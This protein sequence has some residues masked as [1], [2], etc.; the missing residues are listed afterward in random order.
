MRCN[1]P[2]PGISRDLTKPMTLEG[3]ELLPGTAIVVNIG[4]TH[5]YT[6]LCII[7]WFKM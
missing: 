7:I 6:Q 2:V 4:N 3:V 5:W 1:N